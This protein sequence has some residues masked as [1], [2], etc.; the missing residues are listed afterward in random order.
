MGVSEQQEGGRCRSSRLLGW[1]QLGLGLGLGQ[2]GCTQGAQ[3]TMVEEA[4]LY[5]LL[6]ESSISLWF[7]VVLVHGC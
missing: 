5:N 4:E 7:W 6:A 2:W 3:V 1:S